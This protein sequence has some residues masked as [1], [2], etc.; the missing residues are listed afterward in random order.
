[1]RRG[2]A[3]ILDGDLAAISAPIDF[4]GINNY[5][6]QVVAAGDTRDEPRIVRQPNWELTSMG[7]EIYPDGLFDLLV[8]IRDDYAPRSIFITE[9]GAAFSD[10]RAHDGAVRDPEPTSYL[11]D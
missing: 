6:R 8:R 2:R 3:R 1:V 11:R 10:D 5:F 9:N 7:W 4:L